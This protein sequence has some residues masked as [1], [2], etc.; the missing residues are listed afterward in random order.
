MNKKERRPNKKNSMRENKKYPYKNNQ[1]IKF[2]K[3]KD[4][5][6]GGKK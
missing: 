6:E 5:L 3:M 4:N 2:D 1:K